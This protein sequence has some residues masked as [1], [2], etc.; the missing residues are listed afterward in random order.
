M[1]RRRFLKWCLGIGI[2]TAA[3]GAIIYSLLETAGESSTLMLPPGQYEV[4]YL[5]VLS[6]GPTPEFNEATWTL[7]AYGLVKNGFT[8][9]YPDFLKLPTV[10]SVSEFDCVSG[11]TKLG[12]KWEGVRFS[13]IMDLA[14]VTDAAQYATIECENNY[15]TQLPLADLTKDDVLLA[16]R[17]NDQELSPEHGRPLRLVVPGKYGWKSEVG[18][19]NKIHRHTRTGILGIERIQLH[20]QCRYG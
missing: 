10:V 19:K 4:N 7:E 16:Y 18:K 2:T 11:W 20:R 6:V 8:L 12:N 15:T 9:S 14:Q 1:N 3:S 13:T 5:P 17:L